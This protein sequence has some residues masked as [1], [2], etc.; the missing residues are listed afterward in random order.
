VRASD[1]DFD[2]PPERIAQEP[3]PRRDDARLYVLDRAG[4]D[5]HHQIRELPRLL[6]SGALLVVNDTRV[7]PARLRARKP[8]GGRVELLLV[9]P[10]APVGAREV[11][12]CL[13]RASKPLRPGPLVL[14]GERAPAAEILAVADEH[15]DVAFAADEPLLATLERLGEVPLPPYIRRETQRR[16]DRARYQTVYAEVPGAVA[17]PTAGLHF[18]PE[19]LAA[20]A[21]AG[22][23]RVAITLHVGP[24]TFAPLRSD[25]IADDQQLHAERFAVPEATARAIDEA[26]RAGRVVVAV[27]TTVT[28][29]LESAASADGTVRAGAGETRIFIKP[30]HRFRVVDA[31]LT[32]F[33]LPRSSLMML[34]AAFAGRDRILAAY[35]AAVQNNYRFYSY[36][37]AMLIR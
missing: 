18:T 25:E 35:D 30:G 28:R 33:H 34:V 15:V 8:S 2:L 21:D 16:E 10:L 13:G 27:G 11:W 24:G 6:P 32:N 17:A 5:A 20:L 36:G 23:A 14:D 37:D 12:R 31:M 22:I 7:I 19:L 1:F 29:T 4:G 26:R 3:A 9:A